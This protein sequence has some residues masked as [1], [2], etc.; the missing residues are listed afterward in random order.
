MEA[1]KSHD[2]FSV[3][4]SPRKAG[5]VVLSESE[6]L[7]T[8]A[9]NDVSPSSSPK[10]QE[11]EQQC[12]VPAQTESELALSLPFCSTRVLNRLDFLY[13]VYRYKC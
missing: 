13:L 2:V 7:R 10:V 4:W 9:A 11:P 3:R 1:K 5:G 8:R 12:H 6:G